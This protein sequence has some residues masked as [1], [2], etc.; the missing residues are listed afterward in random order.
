MKGVTLVEGDALDADAVARAVSG[1]EAVISTLGPRGASPR[2]LCSRAARIL[3]GAMMTRGVR[4]LVMVTGAMVGHPPARLG[5][6]YRLMLAFPPRAL[7]EL[8]EDRRFS[9]RIIRQSDL[10]WTLVHPPRLAHGP[11]RGRFKAGEDLRLSS[12]A[13]IPRADLARFLV[14][15]AEQGVWKRRAVAVAEP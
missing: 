10:E 2:D 1:Q 3:A 6:F 9:E 14:G 4:R 13:R 12:F 7:R 5:L 15:E 11:A 8:L